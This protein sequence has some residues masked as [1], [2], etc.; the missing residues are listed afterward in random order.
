V[1]RIE[2]PSKVCNNNPNNVDSPGERSSQYAAESSCR[3]RFGPYTDWIGGFDID[4][5]L[6]PVGNYTSLKQLLDKLDSEDTRMFSFGSWRA[7][8]R[9]S[10]IEE[11]VEIT[12]GG[13]DYCGRAKSCFEL[14]VPPNTTMLQ[15]YNCERQRGPKKEVMPAEKQLY[16]ADYVKLHFVH[17][18]TITELTMMNKEETD[19]AGYVWRM[20]VQA[21]PKG[22]FT[23]ELNE[24]TML[25]SKSVARQDTANWKEVCKH[26]KGFCRIGTPYL[27]GAL[28]ANL[29]EDKDG[30]SYNCW[31]NEKVEDYWVPKL[32]AALD[33]SKKPWLN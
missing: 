23:D 29:T 30:W 7:W 19:A 10:K 11:P 5:Y 20:R 13:K 2:W 33:S 15:A 1:T 21:D 32:Q 17:Y 31:V 4:E 22:R 14:K 9:R 3:L 12:K 27:P 26:N 28:E 24:A 16:R 18:S 8:P 6:V 25:H